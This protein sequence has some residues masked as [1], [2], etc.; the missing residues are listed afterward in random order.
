MTPLANQGTIV[1]AQEELY[2]YHV[3]KLF[4]IFC[5]FLT[6]RVFWQHI[7]W[8]WYSGRSMQGNKWRRKWWYGLLY[9]GWV[10]VR[11]DWLHLYWLSTCPPLLVD[12]PALT[13]IFL[14]IVLELALLWGSRVLVYISHPFPDHRQRSCRVTYPHTHVAPRNHCWKHLQFGGGRHSVETC[15]VLE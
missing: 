1:I 14:G 13:D 8:I 15:Q 7:L 6:S 4:I 9:E 10:S 11:D 3:S 5:S 12:I 2:M